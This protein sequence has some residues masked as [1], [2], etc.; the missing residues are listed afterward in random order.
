M[1]L[2]PESLVLCSGTLPFDT[3][4]RQRIEVG[5]EMIEPVAGRRQERRG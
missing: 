1:A 3:P 4:L 5:K 2:G